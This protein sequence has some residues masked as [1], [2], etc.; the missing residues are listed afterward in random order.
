M[1]KYQPRRVAVTG[2]AGLSPIGCDWET[3]SAN[4]KQGHTGIRLFDEWRE[5]SGLNSFLG[6]PV[7]GFEAPSNYPRKMRRMMGRVSLLAVRATELALDNAGLIDDPILTSGR[8]GV[9]HGSSTGSPPSVNAFSQM[10]ETK[11]TDSIGANTYIKMMPHTTAAAIGL[12]FGLKGRLLPSSSACTSGSLSIGLSYEMIK[13]GLQ[14]VMI[15]GGAEE[16]SI[17]EVAAFDTLYATSTLNDTPDKTPKPFDSQRDG[18]VV[19][20]GAA[21]LILEDME[22]A[23]SRGA[24]ILAEVIGFGTNS[25]GKH[26]TQPTMETMA[27]AM[28][29]A[30]ADADLAPEKISYV[31]AHGTAT[32]LGDIAESQATELTLGKGVP[33]SSLKSYI[34]HTLG[35]CGSLEAWMT[36]R[37]TKEGW[38]APTINLTQVDERCGDLDYIMGA[39]RELQCNH[40]MSNNFAFGGVNTSL[41]FSIS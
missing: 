15:A 7:V 21:T 10:L 22:R 26:P 29:L 19:G 27:E 30:L 40:V 34:G 17:A 14:D 38:V 18:L 24:E 41:I 2:M 32:D 1:D 35:A 11:S 4:L 39:P 25:D 16:L 37:M 23:Q 6:A 33:I 36:L 13:F 9:S 3:V 5:Y 12:F 31:N 8:T 28:S 20:E